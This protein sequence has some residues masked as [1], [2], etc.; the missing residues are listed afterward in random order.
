MAF[1]LAYI[2]FKIIN[3]RGNR[4]PVYDYWQLIVTFYLQSF[5]WYCGLCMPTATFSIPTPVRAKI[6]G[7]SLGVDHDGGVPKEHIPYYHR[8]INHERIFRKIPLYVIRAQVTLSQTEGQCIVGILHSCVASCRKNLMHYMHIYCVW[9][10][11]LSQVLW[12]IHSA[13]CH[14][15]VQCTHIYQCEDSAESSVSYT[16][17]VHIQKAYKIVW[18][19]IWR[20]DWDLSFIIQRVLPESLY[21]CVPVSTL[22]PHIRKQL[23]SLHPPVTNLLMYWILPILQASHIGA[24]W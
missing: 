13:I 24:M 10:W 15:Y 22:H 11:G 3:F 16:I 21:D 8:V 20:L 18:L 2:S 9:N 4:K 19:G 12:F 23:P 6:W 17:H 7:C 5:Q 1:N 14:L